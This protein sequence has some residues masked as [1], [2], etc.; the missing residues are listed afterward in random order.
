MTEPDDPILQSAGERSLDAATG[1]VKAA[2][3]QVD[4]V[5]QH[6][7]DKVEAAKRPETYVD[8]LKDMTK[9][10]PLA[11]LAVAFIGGMLFAKRR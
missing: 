9:A 3:D 1:A 10:A 8:F 5:G 4:R 6:F 11:M 2:A 7:K